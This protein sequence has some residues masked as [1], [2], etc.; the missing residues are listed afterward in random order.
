MDT[1]EIILDESIRHS[2]HV[3]RLGGGM[4]RR[5]LQ[6]LKKVDA[7]ILN[8]I[9]ER[10]GKLS[11]ADIET[12]RRNGDATTKRLLILYEQIQ[13]LSDQYQEAIEKPLEKELLEFAKHENGF[14]PR[15]LKEAVAIKYNFVG[16]SQT[17][18]R[19]LVKETPIEGLAGKVFN[20]RIAE[21]SDKVR[22][23]VEDGL[24]VGF[25]QGETLEQ[26]KT[27]ISKIIRTKKK[28]VETL[29]RTSANHVSNQVMAEIAQAN[30][31]VVSKLQWRSVLD[32]R[33]SD[34]CITRD[35]EIYDLQNAKYPPAHPNCRSILVAVT[36]GAG[37]ND[38]FKRGR[39]R[40]S[41]TGN[42]PADL[43]YTEW[44]ARQ[45][46][47]TIKDIIGKRRFELWKQG[48]IELDDFYNPKTEKK[49][50]L[51]Q[52]QR[53]EPQAF[54]PNESGLQ[55]GRFERDDTL[56]DENM[57]IETLAYNRIISEEKSLLRKNKQKHGK[58]VN[59]DDFREL[60]TEDGY[61][62]SNAAAVHEP[63]SYLSKKAYEAGLKQKEPFVA[64]TSG[65]AGSGK[66]SALKSIEKVE[67]IYKDSAVILD[68]NLS[69]FSSA[70]RKVKQ[71]LDAGK[72]VSINYV[73]RD[74]F[75]S[76]ENGVIARMLNN[77]SEGGRLV[78][79]SRVAQ[80]HFGS[81]DVVRRLDD[82]NIDGVEINFVDNSLGRGNA[83]ITTRELLEQK[84]NYGSENSLNRRFRLILDEL[85]KKNIITSEQYSE[86]I[87]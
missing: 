47:G 14:H 55:L 65:G 6:L 64:V 11:Q 30:N 53:R 75:D 7:D 85:L 45:S 78:P 41:M 87:K 26:M 23:K 34:I 70:F 63:S 46:D 44:L 86:L 57:A 39:E 60:F 59:T 58:V 19:R 15:M 21:W 29:I 77:I 61:N 69:G 17:K 56:S 2:I 42:V 9:I 4:V 8:K 40:T 62:G 71:A 66:S 51:K 76:F 33:T 48:E 52:L 68:T 43:K 24:R 84:I 80:N 72:K 32:K 83:K 50:T 73:Y 82:L 3:Q 36:R 54:L 20:K 16:L 1:N 25:L 79:S 10:I 27:R 13:S 12:I 38:E 18:L 81:W 67:Q 5:M 35:G 28:H 49:Y 74:P 31:D 37:S 22:E